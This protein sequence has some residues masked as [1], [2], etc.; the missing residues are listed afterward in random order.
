MSLLSEVETGLEIAL[1]WDLSLEVL[2]SSASKR[3]CSGLL[4][5]ER[6]QKPRRP[7]LASV[8]QVVD[9]DGAWCSSTKRT[10]FTRE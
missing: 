1:E 3:N 6:T 7:T 9:D 4:S 2:S 5:L 10:L 8:Q